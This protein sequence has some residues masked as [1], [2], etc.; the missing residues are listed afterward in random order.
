LRRQSETNPY[1]LGTLRELTQTS[2]LDICLL[3]RFSLCRQTK[4]KKLVQSKFEAPT[5]IVLK[6][7]LFWAKRTDCLQKI[8]SY[9]L[10]AVST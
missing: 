3:G 6:N 9:F 8:T 2:N 7:I 4:Y 1:M 10:R 5:A